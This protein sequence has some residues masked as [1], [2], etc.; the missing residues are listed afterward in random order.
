MF[1][2]RLRDADA[3][4]HDL[5]H[6]GVSGPVQPDMHETGHFLGETM[7]IRKNGERFP[8]ESSAR[9]VYD[10][11]GKPMAIVGIHRDITERKQ[12]EKALREQK[13][14][15]QTIFDHI[16]VL[17]RLMDAAGNVI[18]VNTYWEKIMGWTQEEV[19]YPDAAECEILLKNIQ[20]GHSNWRTFQAVA[21][22]GQRVETKWANVVLSDGSRIGIGQLT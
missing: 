7:C 12:A 10:T 11:S 16:P 19:L 4:I 2:I 5:K 13:E 22:N 20:T 15:L 6:D 18:L 14:M 8:V 3:F 1:L 17:L 9:V 21:K